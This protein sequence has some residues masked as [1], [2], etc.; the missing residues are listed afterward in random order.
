M[1]CWTSQFKLQLLL[2]QRIRRES[3]TATSNP[4]TSSWLNADRP[5]ILDFGLAKFLSD[6]KAE[7]NVLAA[8]ADTVPDQNAPLTERGLT[9]GTVAY[10]SPE[11]ARGQELDTRSDLFSF[12][13]VLYEM[14][15][16]RMAFEGETAGVTFDAI[17]NRNPVSPA[18]LNP[19]LPIGLE[20]I[21]LKT[22]E[23]DRTRRYQSA[24]DLE[25]ALK[26]LKRRSDALQT[27]PDIPPPAAPV[28][29]RNIRRAALIAA[30]LLLVVATSIFLLRQ[31]SGLA[32]RDIILL[33]DFANTTGDPVFDDIRLRKAAADLGRSRPSKHKTPHCDVATVRK[34]P[35]I[36]AGYL[37]HRV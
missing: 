17:L 22:T 14:A 13:A 3:F 33:A 10:M 23:K 11:Q 30:V 7:D 21:I 36:P 4:P 26:Q 2:T 35:Q 12:G 32:E 18:S 37:R 9:V 6:K 25:T 28:K 5:K 8:E 16:G 27:V 1:N 34:T 20:E 31:K 29:K 19:K 24:A 15:T